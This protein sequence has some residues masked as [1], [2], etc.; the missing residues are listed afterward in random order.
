MADEW[1]GKIQLLATHLRVRLGKEDVENFADTLTRIGSIRDEKAR[2]TFE[3]ACAVLLKTTWKKNRRG[4]RNAAVPGF[5]D[6]IRTVIAKGGV[7][8][9]GLERIACVVRAWRKVA[10]KDP[11]LDNFRPDRVVEVMMRIPGDPEPYVRRLVGKGFTQIGTAFH[12]NTFEAAKKDPALRGLF[13][14]GAKN[15]DGSLEGVE[16][17]GEEE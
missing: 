7:E 15:E 3:E 16:I 10:G 6:A 9:V 1:V 5:G 2:T 17:I 4:K 12:S 14:T 13:W 8:H 11:K